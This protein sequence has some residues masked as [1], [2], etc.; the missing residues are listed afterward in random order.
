MKSLI[1][2]F[3]LIPALFFPLSACQD[4][5]PS[6]EPLPRTTVLAKTLTLD[7]AIRIALHNDPTLRA[8][9]HRM[10][11][12]A[13]KTYRS[14]LLPD[15]TLESSFFPGEW[16]L[17]LTAELNRLLDLGGQRKMHRDIA[18]AH[19][20]IALLEFMQREQALI[21]DVRLAYT[22]LQSAYTTEQLHLARTKITAEIARL[23]REREALGD[24][25]RSELIETASS[26][27]SALQEYDEAKDRIQLEI[28][29]MARL[30]GLSLATPVLMEE[31][32]SLPKPELGALGPVRRP[33]IALATARLRAQHGE[34]ALANVAWIPHLEAGPLLTRPGHGKDSEVGGALSVSLPLFNRGRGLGEMAEATVKA[35]EEELLAIE[36]DILMEVELAALQWHRHQRKVLNYHLPH[37]EACRQ[38][39]GISEQ[40][41]PGG[42][43]SHLDVLKSRLR[44]VNS[45]IDLEQARLAEKE[46]RIILFFALGEIPPSEEM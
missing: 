5:P 45:A 15:P 44:E 7:E 17:Q 37:Y 36:A 13:W 23:F 8:G 26:I 6:Y 35:L 16:A 40:A 24:L 34:V 11:A 29:H 33:E 27:A 25:P 4:T 31:D 28:T 2:P 30:L 39:H 21:R 3:A 12:A 22:R 41:L 43:V 9:R 20:D 46:A 19:Q 10:N 18:E 14:T 32:P 38:G 1:I 42:D